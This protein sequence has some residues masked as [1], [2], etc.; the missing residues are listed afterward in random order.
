MKWINTF[1][2]TLSAV[3]AQA[4]STIFQEPF[5]AGLGQC[6]AS[7]SAFGAWV[8]SSTCLK[9][10]L[11]GHSGPGHAMFQGTSCVFGNSLNVVQGDL[12]TP[13]IALPSGTCMLTFHY[14]LTNE[15]GGDTAEGSGGGGDIEGLC[16]YDI[17]SVSIST[18]GGTSYTLLASSWWFQSPVVL[19]FNQN[20]VQQNILLAAYAGQT[21]KLRFNFNSYDA[22]FNNYDGVY[23]DDIAI[24]TCSQVLAAPITAQPGSVVCAGQSMTLSTT[25]LGPYHWNNGATTQSIIVTPG[26]PS[27]FYHLNISNGGNCAATSIYSVNVIPTVPTITLT[28]YSPTICLGGGTSL[29]GF[30]NYGNVTWSPPVISG[31]VQPTVTT[32]Y[33]GS[34]GNVCGITSSVI[35]ITVLPLPMSVTASQSS[36]CAGNPVQFSVTS[37]AN[38]FT[39]LPGPFYSNASQLTF[40][41]LVSTVYTVTGKWFTCAA[42]ATASVSVMPSP[43]VSILASS[44]IICQGS[45]VTLTASGALSYTWQPGGSNGTSLTDVP[46]SNTIYSVQGTGANGCS[47]SK[48]FTVQV[49]PL[50]NLQLNWS[51]D[52]LCIGQS[53]TLIASG[54]SNYSWS[55]GSTNTSVVVQPSVATIYNVQGT[56]NGCSKILSTPAF[57]VISPSLSVSGSSAICSGQTMTLS[58]SGAGSY[59]WNFFNNG[60]TFTLQPLATAIYTVDAQTTVGSI[61]CPSSKTLQ[62]TVHAVPAVGLSVTSPVVCRGDKIILTGSGAN[63]YNWSTGATL[64]AISVTAN[65]GPALHYTITGS[66]INGCSAS[67]TTTVKVQECTGVPL[68]PSIQGSLTVY[69]NPSSGVF[70]ISSDADASLYIVGELGQILR[71]VKLNASNQHTFI[72]CDLT[73]GVYFIYPDL[74]ADAN[75][76]SKAYKIIVR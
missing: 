27:G 10:N 56:T 26:G 52:T 58:A 8:W 70:T 47:T 11:T 13:T 66:D 16:V 5:N 14:S 76:C 68:N 45:P 35:T 4:Q 75:A 41:P 6:T 24:T 62:V 42:T 60:A 69:P 71:Y 29:N 15:C 23:L 7:N 55:V 48:N 72:V 21:V 74:K 33:T 40:S 31:G 25:S 37:A 1:L 49:K 51:A 28:A 43:T 50:P 12:L 53:V 17:L 3:F 20:W 2:I 39:W 63:A 34:A 54:A 61:S 73:Q 9:S 32:T 46:L 18:N 38:T 57:I 19:G 36:V 59:T 22:S 64:A 65:T 44:A 30:S 67:V